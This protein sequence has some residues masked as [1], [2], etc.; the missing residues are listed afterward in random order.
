MKIPDNL[1][2]MYSTLTA[3]MPEMVVDVPPTCDGAS[4]Q[5]LLHTYGQ[6]CLWPWLHGRS[7]GTGQGRTAHEAAAMIRCAWHDAIPEGFIL[8][9]CNEQ[10]SI[11]NGIGDEVGGSFADTITALYHYHMG[12]GA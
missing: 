8:T 6:W 10:W 2:E 7:V 4:P 5:R 12:R 11:V 3:K 9:I 1:A